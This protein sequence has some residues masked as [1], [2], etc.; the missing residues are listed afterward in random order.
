MMLKVLEARNALMAA[1]KM[2]MLK[3]ITKGNKEKGKMTK[4]INLD[5]EKDLHDQFKRKA[6]ELKI[7]HLQTNMKTLM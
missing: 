5:Y 7:C 1:I 4:Q 6:S 3:E 2:I